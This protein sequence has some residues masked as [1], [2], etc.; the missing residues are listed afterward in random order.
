[1]LTWKNDSR[2]IAAL[3][4]YKFN[5]RKITPEQ[6]EKLK[7][8]VEASGYNAPIIIDT[9]DTII[10]GH[11]RWHVL[12]ELGFKTVDVRVPDRKLTEHEFKRINLQDNASF[13][14]WDND[15]LK[16]VFGEFNFE[17]LSL[18]IENFDLPEDEGDDEDDDVT[19]NSKKPVECPECGHEFTP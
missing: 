5:P 3:K 1:M 19:L 6:L 17:E 7:A 16:S 15:I 2:S 11:Q 12:K 14:D 9:D 8:S 10:A 13:A 18:D 4:P